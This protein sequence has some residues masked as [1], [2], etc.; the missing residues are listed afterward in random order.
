MDV[1]E[2]WGARVLVYTNHIFKR[3]H[4]F[5]LEIASRSGLAS[6][7]GDL[8]VLMVNRVAS[9]W[10][11]LK[12]SQ[13]LYGTALHAFLD[14]IDYIS[15]ATQFRLLPAL[16]VSPVQIIRHFLEALQSC[17]DWAGGV[18]MWHRFCA[19]TKM[20]MNL[21]VIEDLAAAFA[22]REQVPLVDESIMTTLL[23]LD[24]YIMQLSFL[25]PLSAKFLD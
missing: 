22:V 3:G 15:V 16:I 14:E 11:Q 21:R 9:V 20:G 19:V 6:D 18:T 8:R 4:R 24:E 10:E 17:A 12:L 23:F 25:F 5:K 13:I 1:E 7:V 2:V